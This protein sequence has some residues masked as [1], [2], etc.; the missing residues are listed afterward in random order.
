L[1]RYQRSI[2]IDPSV[3]ILSSPH[4]LWDY[5]IPNFEV[6]AG[7]FNHSF[8]NTIDDEIKVVQKGRLD[9]P[10]L[11]KELR[12][13]LA[14]VNGFHIQN[15]PLWG[16][17]IARRH[18]DMDTISA[19]EKWFS[20]VLRFSRRDQLTFPFCLQ[21]M[22]KSKLNVVDCDIHKSDVHVWTLPGYKRPG[23]Y[24]RGYNS[25]RFYRKSLKGMVLRGLRGIWN[26]GRER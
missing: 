20:Y 6:T 11:L 14:H 26:L 3:G 22:P 25:F 15:K 18:S 10:L 4:D 8:R 12:H 24:Y 5:L 17:V 21:E 23:H 2:Y 16:G 19:M 9:H 13:A 1:Q 7:F